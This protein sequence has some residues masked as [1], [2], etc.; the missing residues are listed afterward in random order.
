MSNDSVRRE[1]EQLQACLRFA[2]NE[3]LIA[4]APPI[5]KPGKAPPR[6]RWLTPEEAARL[7]RTARNMKYSHDY[8]PLFI[9]IALYTGARKDAVLSLRWPQ[10]D[11]KRELID[12]RPGQVSHNKGRSVVPIP[13]RLLR[14]LKTAKK[15]GTQTGYVV[16]IKRTIVSNGVETVTHERLGDIKKGFREACVKAGLEKVTPH[17]LRHTA[18]S[19]MVQKGVPLFEVARYLG[20]SSTLMVERTYGHLAPE[21]LKRA[22]ESW[23]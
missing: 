11:F 8:L 2:Y 7:L 15:H 19:W 5:W 23:G 14:E 18:A 20:H 1:L 4:S 6:S 21:H 9:L 13:R 17:T 12:F 3:G 22:K 16:H 10:V